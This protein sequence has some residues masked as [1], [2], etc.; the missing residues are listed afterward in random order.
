MSVHSRYKNRLCCICCC[1]L[2]C[3]KTHGKN[4]SDKPNTNKFRKFSKTCETTVKNVRD[5]KAFSDED[6]DYL[7]DNEADLPSYIC[8]GCYRSLQRTPEKFSPELPLVEWHQKNLKT[9][10]KSAH[11][12]DRENS[13]NQHENDLAET[14]AP[15]HCENA[16]SFRTR[17]RHS[18][19]I[20]NDTRSPRRTCRRECSS[21]S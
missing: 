4:V 12:S 14:R 16:R 18:G 21:P 10:N 8:Y 7:L 2:P 3:L 20:Q 13:H 1:I 9:R 17:L 19:Q 5:S 11:F 15:D 6:I